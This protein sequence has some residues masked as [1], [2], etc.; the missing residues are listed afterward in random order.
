MAANKGSETAIA[1][2]PGVL[3]PGEMSCF[4]VY[5]EQEGKLVLYA[6][7]GD[8]LTSAHQEKLASSEVRSV[9]VKGA[10]LPSLRTFIEENLPAILV[11]ETIPVQERA[12]LWHDHAA[13]AARELFDRRLARPLC[14]L[15][16]NRVTAMVR[17]TA[18]FFSR[19]D[20]LRE[21]SR[22]M[23]DGRELHQHG[24]AVMVTSAAVINA[25]A[26]GDSELMETCCIGAIMH[27]VGKLELPEMLMGRDPKMMDSE[28]RS[29]YERHP[30]L[31]VSV[32]AAVQLPQDALQCILFHHEHDNGSGFPSGACQDMLPLPARVVGLCDTFENLVSKASWRSRFT[33]F[34]A[35][36]LLRDRH[37]LYG[38]DI[39]R[40]LVEVLVRAKIA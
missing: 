14:S 12:R 7:K 38:M 25:L 39:Q 30:V 40:A 33:P 37:N 4:S 19:A 18:R 23:S 28:D 22:F 29:A 27:D 32:C 31:G 5:L 2:P 20:A 3:R 9:Y 24:L 13:A 8:M 1:I 6:R 11:D 34:E 10:D 16:F 15:R 35:L 26:P 36:A 21:L 17:A